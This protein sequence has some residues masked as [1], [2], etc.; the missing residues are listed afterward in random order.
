MHSPREEELMGAYANSEPIVPF[1]VKPVFLKTPAEKAQDSHGGGTNG[2][3]SSGGMFGN[4]FGW[5]HLAALPVF[6]ALY[7]LVEK[8]PA[9]PGLSVAVL[10]ACLR[11]RLDPFRRRLALAPAAFATLLLVRRIVTFALAAGAPLVK[12]AVKIDSGLSWLP[13]FF[14]V[15]LFYMPQRPSYS[16]NFFIGGAGLLL[17]SGLLP[18]DGFIAIFA[19]T[20]YF[21]FFAVIVVLAIDFTQ[22]GPPPPKPLENSHA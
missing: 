10:F 8:Q 2:L 20:E 9:L 18:G 21:T 7:V 6:V 17:A 14:A 3:A 12:N 22:P 1:H 5:L 16:G 19:A 4:G 13:L 11:Y 15:A